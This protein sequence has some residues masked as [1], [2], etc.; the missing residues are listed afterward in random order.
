MNSTESVTDVESLL[1]KLNDEEIGRLI[2][3][4]S[5]LA[6]ISTLGIFGNAIVTHIYRTRYKTS[7]SKLF[8][9]SV[10]LI[11]L[12]SCA[13]AIPLEI[14][15]LLD[16]YTFDNIWLCKVSRFF[17]TLGT[18][19]S[20]FILVFI[21]IDRY[22]KVCQPLARQITPKS[23]RFL[24]LMSLGL[25]LFVA[26]PALF[27]YGQKSFDIDLGYI[28]ISGT[29]CS[30]SD[31]FSDSN[32][33]FYYTALFSVLFLAGITCMSILYCFIGCKIKRQARKMSQ[34]SLSVRKMSIPMSSSI[35]GDPE[36]R[37]SGEII[38]G[39]FEK[40]EVARKKNESMGTSKGNGR[41]KPT[42]S[43]SLNEDSWTDKKE[44]ELS[45]EYN[46]SSR[47]NSQTGRESLV[48]GK[49][50][51]NGGYVPD[52]PDI[53]EVDT[54]NH[55]EDTG[56]DG[57]ILPGDKTV[58]GQ[59]NGTFNTSTSTRSS[60]NGDHKASN[61]TLTSS[62][63]TMKNTDRTFRKRVSSIGSRISHVL[64]RMTSIGGTA[65][66]VSLAGTLRKNQYL[67][68]ARARKTA[69]IMFVISLAYIITYLPHLILMVTRQVNNMFVDDLPDSGRS[70]YK[71]FL[72]SFF[73]N[74]AINPIIYS[75]CDSRFRSACGEL[76]GVC[77]CC[78]GKEK[79]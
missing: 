73:L 46:E 35:G 57:A 37:K 51:K 32:L 5:F 22:R 58:E 3:T 56:D 50:N 2:P 62:S 39:A 19:S 31:T 13:V 52:C 21:A 47:D 38:A 28:Q 42:R 40:Y 1:R 6:I 15:L 43:D 63:E 33:P 16:Q 41:N 23:A 14:Q 75:V 30:T 10:A 8:I 55:V 65:T 64:V 78:T 61:S 26:W 72:R 7:N 68:Q 79:K 12:L 25:G 66:N 70:A 34:C 69:F 20:S 17:N 74:C 48:N 4:V 44:F 67:K 36:P 53:N 49:G 24:C 60:S 45:Y 54:P 27:V 11:D 29:E 59:S 76:F 18:C 9:I 71:F 77:R